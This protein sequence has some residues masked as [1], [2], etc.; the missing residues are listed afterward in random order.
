MKP[1]SYARHRFLP[2]VIRHAVW[3]NLRFTLSYRDVDDL[4]AERGLEVSNESIRR[5]VLKF[6][7]A[8][9]RNLRSAR[10][11][12]HDHWHLDEMLFSIGGQ[13]MYM[14]RAV[15]GEGEVLDILIQ[16]RR[17]KAA[18]LKLLRK[19]LK[20]QGFAPTAIVTDKLRSYGA[21]L[22]TIGFSGRHEQGLRA[23]NRAENSHQPVRRREGKMGGLQITHVSSTLHFA[24]RRRLQ[25]L[26]CST[27]PDL[28][29]NASAVSSRGS[30]CLA[31]RDGCCRVNPELNDAFART[32][33]VN[34]SKP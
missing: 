18:A 31:R 32:R 12:P 25:C 4:L 14:W 6:G 13:R 3:L 30:Q 7:P 1:I 21:A 9:A 2:D 11:R 24:P 10:P 8:I 33:R 19:L 26:Q 23:N 20:K 5:W 16:R 34:V 28:P 27:T 17:D 15:D 29:S 22:Q